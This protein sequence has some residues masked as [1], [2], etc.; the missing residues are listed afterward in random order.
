MEKPAEIS[1]NGVPQTRLA[2]V[3]VS[4][5]GTPGTPQGASEPGGK[6]RIKVMF[7]TNLV[8]A[9]EFESI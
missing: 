5:P 8:F 3:S 4:I 9:T 7:E 2:G 6:L 1:S